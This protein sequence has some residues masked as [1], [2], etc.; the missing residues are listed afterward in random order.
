M[1]VAVI[2]PSAG[3]GVRLKSK[4]QKPYIELAGK[5]ILA[6]TLLKLSEN[7]RVK[8][9]ILAVA[10]GKTAYAGKMI[11]KYGIKNVKLVVGGR[12]R[13]D[14]VYNALRAVSADIDYVLIH[15]GIRPFVSSELIVSLLKTASKY[16]AAIAGV[17]VKPTLKI[18][19]KNNF[20]ES[21]PSRK[22]YWEAQTPQVFKRNLIEKAYKSAIEKNIQATDDS[23]LVEKIGVKPKIVMGSYSNIKITT[24]ED[25]ELAKILLKKIIRMRPPVHRITSAPVKDK[26]DFSGVL[27]R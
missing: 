1:N 19:G 5:P 17:P 27:V 10:K 24:K 8:E 7:K 23:M 25:L 18:I 11:N 14:S 6:Y 15:D 9:I 22:M 13:R 26:K 12:E 21:T 20:I 3:K 4:I 2:V 16:G